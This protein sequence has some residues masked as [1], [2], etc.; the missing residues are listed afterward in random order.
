MGYCCSKQV[1]QYLT[2]VLFSLLYAKPSTARIRTTISTALHHVASPYSRVLPSSRLGNCRSFTFSSRASMS[3]VHTYT[4]HTQQSNGAKVAC[5]TCE[6]ARSGE[7]A[8]VFQI[9][10]NQILAGACTKSDFPNRS[11]ALVLAIRGRATRR[12]R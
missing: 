2:F 12:A 8:V 10:T 6:R 11:T 7:R 9:I 3:P 4:A 5:H 1:D